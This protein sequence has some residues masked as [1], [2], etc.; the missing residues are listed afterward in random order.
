MIRTRNSNRKKWQKREKSRSK[1]VDNVKK[2]IRIRAKNPS[3]FARP[4]KTRVMRGAQ[5]ATHEKHE[6]IF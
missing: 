5:T 6:K 4:Q 3:R 2:V 1:K